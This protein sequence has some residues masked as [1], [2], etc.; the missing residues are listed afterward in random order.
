MDT[1]TSDFVRAGSLAELKARGRLVV[2]GRHPP[3][4]RG[5]RPRSRLR[6]R[7]PVPAHGLSARARQRRGRHPD[8]S[9]ASRPVRSR[10][11]LHVRSVGRRRADLSRSRCATARSGSSRSFGHADPAA[12]LAPSA[13]RRPGPR[14]RPGHRQGGAWSTRRRR[15]PGESRAADRAVRGAEP[16]RLGRRPD[17]P[18]GARQ[19]AVRCCRRR[20]PISPSS[21]APAG[22]QPTAR[23]KPPRRERAPLASF[24]PTSRRSSAGCGAGRPCVIAKRPSAPCSLR[25]PPGPR[26]PRS[27]SLL[28]AAGDGS[29]LRRRRTF[30]R[31]HQQ[32]LRVPRS[33]RLGARGRRAAERGRPD[34][35][36]ARRRGSDRLAPSGGSRRPCARRRRRSCRGCCRGPRPGA[37]VGSCGTRPRP[38]LAMIRQQ[39]WM[40]SSRRSRRRASRRSR[41]LPCLRGGAP[42][43]AV[44]HSQ[45]ARRL[46]DGASRL[47][48]RQCRPPGADADWADGRAERRRSRLPAGFFMVRWRSISPATSMC[49]PRGS[50]ARPAI[51]STTF[52]T[53]RGALRGSAGRLRSA[54]AGRS[55]RPS[56]GAPSHAWPPAGRADCNV[57][58]ALL[59]EDAGFHAYQ[60]L[61]AGVRQFGEW[62][63]TE[64]GRHIL[65]AVA[66]YLAAHS[67][68][69]RAT[70]QTA[71]IA[72]RLLRGGELH[73]ET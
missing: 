11:R 31:L 32:G 7:Q 60:M 38:C 72:Q 45:R 30:A 48:L 50:Q 19:S 61:E 34:G 8:L 39:S 37:L 71:D 52:P 17:H 28:F 4:P 24:S 46:G 43:G 21:T 63:K 56:C 70:F 27:P 55:G 44:R 14:S 65:I 66:R 9:L 67:P 73:H 3:D 47:H 57:G 22:S 68:T 12:P 36:G 23:V 20:R 33:D 13:R 41:P 35:R 5:L 62:G 54:T 58:R 59:R 2:R 15:A 53:R 29:R 25:S 18:H 49:R 16:G 69:E 40:P 1:L 26:R 64:Q 10:E 6:A 51:G 42:G